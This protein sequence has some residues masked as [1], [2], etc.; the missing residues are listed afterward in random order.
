MVFDP[1]RLRNWNFGEQQ[2]SFEPRD[3]I[4][5]ALGVG[6]PITPGESADLN[7]L[8]EDRLRV[9]PSF[10]VTLASPGMWPKAPE[11]AIDW[12]K[13]LHMAQAVEFHRPLPADASVTSKPA[14]VAL[15]DRGAEKG[16]ICILRRRVID[17]ADGTAYCTIDQTLALR[18]NGGFGGEPMPRV[19]R[20]VIPLRTPDHLESVFTSERAA[21]IYRLSGD[22]N[23]IHA[24]YQLARKAG[25]QRPILHGL[26]SYGTACAVILRAFCHGDPARMK[27]LNLRFAGVVT[28]GDRLDF[29]CWNDGGRV[30]F[31]GK[32]GDR[33]VIDQGVA[34][35][36][37]G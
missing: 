36:V 15:Y 23:P 27:S 10:A 22:R 33:T 18:G 31:E 32:V 25:Y 29:S 11:L 34:E 7:F 13:L 37:C 17:A 14:I 8:L 28:P 30:L 3:A 16:A 9:L 2:Q 6:L 4:L 20:P 21:L 19:E 35:I 24:D 26:A 1:D 12:V 5:Y